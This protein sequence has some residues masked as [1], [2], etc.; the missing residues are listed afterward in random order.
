[1]ALTTHS[2]PLWVFVACS[3]VNQTRQEVR[4]TSGSVGTL[5]GKVGGEWQLTTK[6]S[7]GLRY[8]SYRFADSLRAGS[9][10]ILL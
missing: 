6:F 5:C 1:M 2:H 10:L 4:P 9:V 3:R 7:Q 8:V